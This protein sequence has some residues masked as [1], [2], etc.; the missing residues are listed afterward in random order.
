[1]AGSG[2]RRPR[3]SVATALGVVA[4]VVAAAAV[5]VPAA[6]A[7]AYVALGDSYAAGPL[8]PNQLPDPAG[9]WRSDHNYAHLVAQARG[10]PLLD[11]TCSAASTT[12]LTSAQPVLGGA[13]R[14]QLDALGPGVGV[15]SLQIGGNDI[16]FLDIVQRCGTL[17]PVGTPCRDA[18]LRG[19]TDVLSR[20]IAATGPRVGA[21]LAEIRRRSPAARVLVLGYPAIL[22]EVQPGCWPVLPIAPGD[23]SYLRDKEKELNAM[24]A[25]RAAAAGATYVDVYGPSLGHDACQ[26]PGARWVEPLVPLALSAPAHPNALGMRGTAGALLGATAG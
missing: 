7:A 18:Y 10:W 4:F 1:V 19:G 17:L 8:V 9:C 15:V 2:M 26:P 24:L 25:A 13:N 21:A 16:G 12:D 6:A 23:V 5:P 3:G 20:R 14:P 22:P 11:V